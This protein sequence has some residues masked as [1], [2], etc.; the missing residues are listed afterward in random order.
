MKKINSFDTF[1]ED[2]ADMLRP[3]NENYTKPTKPI[4]NPK[5]QPNENQFEVY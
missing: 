3:I 5:N 2:L 4:L 1:F